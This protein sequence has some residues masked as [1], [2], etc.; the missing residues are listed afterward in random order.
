[1]KNVFPRPRRGATRSGFSLLELLLTMTL[2]MVAL[3][4]YLRSISDSVDLRRSNRERAMA[5]SAA[6]EVLE[7]MQASDFSDLLTTF[8]VAPGNAFDVPGLDALDD[9]PD[10]SV[11][12]IRFP[13]DVGGDVTETPA[14]DFPLMPRDLNVDGDAADTNVTADMRLLPVWIE[15]EWGGTGTPQRLEFV[16]II[17]DQGVTP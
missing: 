6:Q 15:I 5:A 10:G 4:G 16:T 8:G 11:G 12:L 1:M 3:L 17:G 14:G 9:D 13:V 2:L 7:Q